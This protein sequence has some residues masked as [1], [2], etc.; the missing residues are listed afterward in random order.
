MIT[1]PSEKDE[2]YL[3][4]VEKIG[5]SPDNIKCLENVLS[6]E[7]HATLLDYVKTRKRWI[8]EPWDAYSVGMD[9]LPINILRML[10]KIFTLVHKSATELYG[11]DINFFTTD[12]LALLKFEKGLALYPHVDTNSAESNHIASIYYINDDYIG[13]ELCFPDLNINIKPTPNS[14]IFFPG[15]ENYLHEVRTIVAGDRYSSSMWFQYTGSTFTK[16]AE[17][18]K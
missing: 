3:R 4:N 9:Q 11:V 2:I 17:W 1:N 15:N 8:L 14:V 12:N 7:D 6:E 16:N 18:Y 13:G 5:S 10:E